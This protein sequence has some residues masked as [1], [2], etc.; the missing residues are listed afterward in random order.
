LR[1]QQYELRNRFTLPVGENLPVPPPEPKSGP[2]MRLA[3]FYL[4]TFVNSLSFA[5]ITPLVPFILLDAGV[6]TNASLGGILVTSHAFFAMVSAPLLGRASDRFGRQLVIGTTVLGTSISYVLFAFSGNLPMLFLARMLAGFMAGNSGVLQAALADTTTE[7]ERGGAMSHYSAAWALGFVVGP[8]LS[9]ALAIIQRHTPFWGHEIT[10]LPGLLA[11][12]LALVSMIFVWTRFP[13]PRN[14]YS[15]RPEPVEQARATSNPVP[16][17][18]LLVVMALSQSGL[19]AM[20]SFWAHATFGWSERGIGLLMSWVAIWVIILQLLILPKLL[21]RWKLSKALVAGLAACVLGCVFLCLS[22]ASIPIIAVSA[23]TLFCGI[24]ATQ[25][26]LNT[27][28]SKVAP[29]AGRG[30]VMGIAAGSAALGRVVGPGLFGL[31]FSFAGPT[32][33]YIFVLSIAAAALIWGLRS[34]VPRA[35]D[36]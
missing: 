13:S 12:V 6:G 16:F 34:K 32:G 20:T 25:T 4:V 29:P 11:A 2:S 31:L 35:V 26:T 21:K 1:D 19:V 30:R 24:S 27:I 18:V 8:L 14:S 5:M 15:G 36:A 9:A 33:P 28:M 17:L 23:A 7:Q 10:R 3:T 22:A